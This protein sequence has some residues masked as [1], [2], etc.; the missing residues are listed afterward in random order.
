MQAEQSP[1]SPKE[2]EAENLVWDQDAAGSNPVA[3]T[4]VSGWET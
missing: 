1:T 2:K 4:T 3:P